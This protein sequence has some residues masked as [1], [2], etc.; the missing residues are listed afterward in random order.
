MMPSQ[1]RRTRVHR[2]TAVIAAIAVAIG[3]HGTALG[4]ADAYG[5]LWTGQPSTPTTPAL[6]PASVALQTT[7]RGDVLLATS[8]R[9]ALCGSPT[10]TTS[11]EAC[12]DQ[13]V[14]YM[15]MDLSACESRLDPIAV[16]PVQMMQPKQV[17]ALDPIEAEALVEELMREQQQPKPPPPPQLQPQ[18]PKP[19]PPPP[20]PPPQ[21]PAQIVENVKPNEDKEPEN[22]RFLA[23]H[24]TSVEK[25]KVARGARNEPMVAKS[26]P[27]ELTAKQEPPKEDPSIQ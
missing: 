6:E 26:K 13:A 23:E 1:Q 27:E 3:A 9:V 12:Y 10:R 17:A 24:N 16:A 21:R 20:P 2:R 14:E 11:F 15:W 7:C 19:P 25:Q 18:Q 22:A 4:V 5:I 8:A